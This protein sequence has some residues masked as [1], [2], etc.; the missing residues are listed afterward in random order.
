MIGRERYRGRDNG[1][2]SKGKGTDSKGRQ[3][4]EGKGREGCE[5]KGKSKGKGISNEI[6]RRRRK[7]FSKWRGI[8]S[9]IWYV[10]RKL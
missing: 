10:T 9:E 3:R 6:D 4:H 8:V 2:E 7:E 5:A 1:K